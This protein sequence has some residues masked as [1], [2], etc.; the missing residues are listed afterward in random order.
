MEVI[1]ST[2]NHTVEALK[3]SHIAKAAVPFLS[4][5]VTWCIKWLVLWVI[6]QWT[7]TETWLDGDLNKRHRFLFFLCWIK[8]N[9]K[10]TYSGLKLTHVWLN[11][12][13]VWNVSQTYRMTENASP[14]PEKYL[15]IAYLSTCSTF[16]YVAARKSLT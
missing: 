16:I 5:P 12:E 1:G 6:S 2:P 15:P 4:K 13:H 7:L 11:R 10:G 3:M 8:L 9:Q 14:V